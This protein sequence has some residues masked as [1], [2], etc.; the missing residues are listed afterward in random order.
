MG[1]AAD[2][3]FIGTKR[4]IQYRGQHG[5]HLGVT[6]LL[7]AW[8]EGFQPPGLSRDSMLTLR[9][10]QRVSLRLVFSTMFNFQMFLPVL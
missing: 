4:E 3:H 7:E 10:L 6:E 2:D 1:K 8:V 9:G 5:L